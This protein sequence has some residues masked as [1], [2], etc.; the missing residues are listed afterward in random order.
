M[1][2]DSV[3]LVSVVCGSSV[4]VGVGVTWDETGLNEKLRSA[5]TRV[6]ATEIWVRVLTVDTGTRQ[7]YMCWIQRLYQIRDDRDA[8]QRRNAPDA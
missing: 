4:G 6:E 7:R 2:S 3:I 8:R 5:E 1:T